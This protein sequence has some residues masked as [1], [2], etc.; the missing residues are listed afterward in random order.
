LE[1]DLRPGAHAFVELNSSDALRGS[2]ELRRAFRATGLLTHI[3]TSGAPDPCSAIVPSLEVYDVVTGRT[4]V[5]LTRWR[6]SI[7]PAAGAAWDTPDRDSTVALQWLTGIEWSGSGASATG[8]N[9]VTL[10]LR[11]P[12]R[13]PVR[14][15]LS[16][17][18]GR[19]QYGPPRGFDQRSEGSSGRASWHVS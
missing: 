7:Q 16:D 11:P 12:I 6:S 9:Q 17:R 1:L 13:R 18:R 2:R 14:Q 3:A 4:S 15:G 8:A 10:F 19:R 5:A